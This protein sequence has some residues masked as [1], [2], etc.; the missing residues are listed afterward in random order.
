MGCNNVDSTR[1]QSKLKHYP[2]TNAS[3]HMGEV[4]TISHQTKVKFRTKSFK[5]YKVL[6]SYL[7]PRL[8]SD[9]YLLDSPAEQ[10]QG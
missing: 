1:Y 5:K 7:D 3:A 6:T 8:L 2:Y 4:C 10:N 9:Q